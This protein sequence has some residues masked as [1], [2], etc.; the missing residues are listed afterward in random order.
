MGGARYV[1]GGIVAGGHTGDQVARRAA[2]IE[3]VRELLADKPMSSVELAVC[4]GVPTTTMNGYLYHLAD[5]GEVRRVSGGERRTK[6]WAADEQSIE[7][8]AEKA[9][10]EHALRARIVRASQVGMQRDS[11]VQALFGPAA[12]AQL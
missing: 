7:E 10:S 12:G 1:R 5:L 8:S 4:V 3:R 2:N 11:L 6:S 9:K